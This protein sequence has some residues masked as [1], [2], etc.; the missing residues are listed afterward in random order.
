MNRARRHTHAT[1]PRIA[2]AHP[3]LRTSAHRTRTSAHPHIRVFMRQTALRISRRTSPLT[4]L[5]TS[6]RTSPSNPN[7]ALGGCCVPPIRDFG[8]FAIWGH[9]FRCH[10]LQHI[11]QNG[12]IPRFLDLIHDRNQLAAC[13]QIA[14]IAKSALRGT[15]N[16]AHTTRHT[17][18]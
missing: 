3:R 5:W 17:R 6:R 16:T 4:S 2:L 12:S 8:V 15:P 11:L 18:T 7:I 9:T 1:H 14:K 10:H 13:P